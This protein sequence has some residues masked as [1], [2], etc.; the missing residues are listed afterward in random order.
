MSSIQHEGIFPGGAEVKEHKWTIYG[1]SYDENYL[2]EV[3]VLNK[4]EMWFKRKAQWWTQDGKVSREGDLPAVLFDDEGKEWW[5]D[6]KIHR[7]GDEPAVIQPCS[8]GDE[9]FKGGYRNEWWKNGKR[10][11]GGEKPAVITSDGLEE[12]WVDG[13]LVRSHKGT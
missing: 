9:W 13:K 12:W 3:I 10:H 2:P 4:D 7:D 5:K 11:R 6:G 8:S 1:Q